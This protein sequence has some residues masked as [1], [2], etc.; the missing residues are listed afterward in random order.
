M[1]SNIDFYTQVI[2][3]YSAE[4]IGEVA[5]SLTATVKAFSS[6]TEAAT[7]NSEV[8]TCNPKNSNSCCLRTFHFL[9]K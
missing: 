3:P 9:L 4:P 2:I 8:F 6:G 5:S 7:N 1:T